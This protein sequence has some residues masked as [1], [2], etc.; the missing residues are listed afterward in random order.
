ML[1]RETTDLHLALERR[2]SDQAV[3]SREDFLAQVSHDLRGLMAAHKLYLAM[4]VKQAG[5][6]EHSLV[7]VPSV[8]TL[9]QIGAQMDRMIGALVAS[10]R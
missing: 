7:L 8:A 1:E 2:S 3:M 10:W 4:L 5:D 6:G 9:T